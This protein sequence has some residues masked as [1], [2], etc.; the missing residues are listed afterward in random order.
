[1]LF[2]IGESVVDLSEDYY[3]TMAGKHR[4]IGLYAGSTMLG[5]CTF[6]VLTGWDDLGRFYPRAMWSIP[7]D[8]ADGPV[9]Y[10]DK[11]VTYR[12]SFSI[13]RQIE[14]EISQRVPSWQTAVWYRPT[15]DIDRQVIYYRRR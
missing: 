8:V 13:A 3:W 1:M 9:V 10:L 12:W 15:D 2:D 6:F 7:Q 4:L 14:A 5:L 11:L